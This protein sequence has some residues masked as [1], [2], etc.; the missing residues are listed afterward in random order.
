[1]LAPQNQNAHTEQAIQCIMYMARTFMFHASLHWI[2]QNSDDI[3]LCSFAVVKQLGWLYNQLP[4]VSRA[5]LPWLWLPG[6]ALTMDLLHYH[7]WGCPVFVP[8]AK[9]QIDQKLPKWNWQACMSQFLDFQTNTPI[10]G[11]GW[12]FL[13]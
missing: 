5:L 8:E 6:S 2:E 7:V 10:G 12:E 11:L 4:N 13:Q 9:L 1:M 3:Y